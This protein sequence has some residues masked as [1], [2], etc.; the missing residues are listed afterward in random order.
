MVTNKQKADIETWHLTLK[1]KLKHMLIWTL[2]NIVGRIQL[3]LEEVAR[4]SVSSPIWASLVKK[5]IQ[6]KNSF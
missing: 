4:S 3:P 2:F 6:P 1:F 5:N